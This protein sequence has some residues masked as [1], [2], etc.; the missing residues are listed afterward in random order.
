MRE[1]EKKEENVDSMNIEECRYVYVIQ[2]KIR[3][4]GKFVSLF[5]FSGFFSLHKEMIMYDK[6]H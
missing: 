3:T 6:C 1:R 5:A 4:K 2:L